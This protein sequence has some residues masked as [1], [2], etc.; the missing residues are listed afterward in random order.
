ME[1][2]LN[3]RQ[4]LKKYHLP[5][6][7]RISSNFTGSNDETCQII[8]N[9]RQATRPTSPDRHSNT[10]ISSSFEALAG[11][12]RRRHQ[13]NQTRIDCTYRVNQKKPNET[14]LAASR[15]TQELALETENESDFRSLF[16]PDEHRQDDQQFRSLAAFSSRQVDKL[17]RQRAAR[18][19]DLVLRMPRASLAASSQ[20]QQV[21][22]RK[23]VEF[24]RLPRDEE[25]QPDWEQRM[26]LVPPSKRP[27]LSKL[28]LKQPLLLYKAC[29]KLEICAYVMDPKNELNEKSGDPIYFPHNYPGKWKDSLPTWALANC[30]PISVCCCFICVESRTTTRR[31]R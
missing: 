20:P 7:V 28:N 13:L 1:A 4:F 29:K 15:S 25:Q 18:A 19:E 8:S 17:L 3:A 11:N 24:E 21:A 26:R 16:A 31:R 10:S 12:E 27:T 23:S 22:S 6:L 9:R 2:E 14:R 5:Q 30:W